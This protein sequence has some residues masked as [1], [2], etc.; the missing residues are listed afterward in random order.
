MNYLITMD[1]APPFFT[2]W[3]DAENN[4]RDDINMVV[5]DLLSGAYTTDGTTWL[6]I[7]EDHL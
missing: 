1:D 6:E 3:F 2:N 7:E 5:Y 4:F